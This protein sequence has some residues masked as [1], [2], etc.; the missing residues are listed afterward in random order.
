M[1]VRGVALTGLIAGTVLGAT[2]PA[3][4]QFY[5]KPRNIAGDPVRGD[6][7]G[8]AQA[9]PGATDAERR[10]GLVWT[11]RAALNVAALQCDFEPTLLT[12]ANYNAVL[13]DHKA[14]LA[15]SWSTLGAYFARTNGGKATTAAPA[16]GKG[17]TKVVRASGGAGQNALDHY[18]TQTY[19]SFSTV[20]AQLNFC[21]AADAIGRMAVFVPRG[22]FGY[23]AE[24]RMRELRNSLVPSGEEMFQRSY[25]AALPMQLPRFDKQCWDKKGNWVAKKCGSITWPPAGTGM[26]SR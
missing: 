10:A 13:T 20:G 24:Q 5:M 4:A 23:L 8:I 18:Q 15:D 16:K 3:S 9:L 1:G 25:F 12:V 22:Q 7:P 17:K 14:E 2:T 19:S 11:M 26:A 6:E 21:Q